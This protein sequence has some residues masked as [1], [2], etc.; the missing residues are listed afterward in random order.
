MT[1]TRFTW[2]CNVG[3]NVQLGAQQC[4]RA[5]QLVHAVTCLR[6]EG[7]KVYCRPKVETLPRESLELTKLG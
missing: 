2:A 3:T 4:S 6:G 1:P 5:R 7:I